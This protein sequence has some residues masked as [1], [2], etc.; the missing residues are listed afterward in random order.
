[1]KW[2]PATSM[3]GLGTEDGASGTFTTTAIDSSHLRHAVLT[4]N[5]TASVGT[6]SLEIEILDENGTPVDTLPSIS[7]SSSP[8]GYRVAFDV[9]ARQLSLRGII[10][11]GSSTFTHE[12]IILEGHG[13]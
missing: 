9:T 7:A 3:R 11:D 6:G 2:Y 1:M 4:I 8:R 5:V 12:G 13:Y 10:D